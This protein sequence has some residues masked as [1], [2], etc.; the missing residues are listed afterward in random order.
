V[1]AVLSLQ[2]RKHLPLGHSIRS[3]RLGTSQLGHLRQFHLGLP[4]QRMLN[5]HLL[6]KLILFCPQD[7]WYS[8]LLLFPF[9]LL[10]LP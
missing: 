4:E 6:F 2:C 5:L 10:F 7:L 8:L 9:S 1:V 3:I